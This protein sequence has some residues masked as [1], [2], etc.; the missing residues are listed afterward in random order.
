MFDCRRVE[1]GMFKNHCELANY[2]TT[3]VLQWKMSSRFP[4]FVSSKPIGER[5]VQSGK[6][7]YK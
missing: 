4:A 6:G 7:F 5:I 3:P 2:S 1:F